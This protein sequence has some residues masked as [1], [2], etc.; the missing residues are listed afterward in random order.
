MP[1][2]VAELIAGWV[3]RSPLKTCVGF[4]VAAVVVSGVAT[5][6]SSAQGGTV[7]ELSNLNAWIDKLPPRLASIH[8]TGMITAP[9]PCYDA[10]AAF[11]GVDTSNPAIYLVK[12][13]LRAHTSYCIQ[14]LTDIPFSYRELTY[15]DQTKEMMILSEDDSETIAVEITH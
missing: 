7:G 13:T 9:T 5:N 4:A 11:D 8:A 15:D 10:L 12:I 3:P 2:T 14:V 6:Q 1:Q